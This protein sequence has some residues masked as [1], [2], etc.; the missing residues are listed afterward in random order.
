MSYFE[1][2]VEIVSVVGSV[3][4][5]KTN[6]SRFVTL[7]TDGEFALAAANSRPFGVI[8]TNQPAK[9]AGRVAFAGT[10]PVE[11]GGTV[12]IGDE[13]ASGANGVAVKATGTGAVPIGIARTAGGSG[14]PIAVQLRFPGL[15]ALT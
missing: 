2:S 8:T 6:C 12:A 15:V 1:E 13:I 11:A 3:E 14:A 9:A 7:N 4:I 5:T 10:V